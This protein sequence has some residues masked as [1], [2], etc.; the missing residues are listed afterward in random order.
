MKLVLP[1]PPLGNNYKRVEVR[2]KVNG[3]G[4]RTHYPHFYLTKE[5]ETYKR[6]VAQYA[7]ANGIF[8]SLAPIALDV[9][10]FRARKRGDI[11]G[12]LKVLLDAL[13]GCAYEDDKQVVKINIE[14]FDDKEDPRV[15][16]DVTEHAGRQ[17]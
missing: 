17:G 16:V 14:R 4:Y 13:Q 3:S 10:V 2:S 7:I 15:E 6:R 12:Y 9:R 5:A 1:L 8:P 11:D